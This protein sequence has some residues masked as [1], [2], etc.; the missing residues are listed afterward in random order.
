[1]KMGGADLDYAASVSQTSD[2]GY[3]AVGTTE[4]FGTYGSVWLI[5]LSSDPPSAPQ[6]LIA[7]AEGLRVTLR[8]R[9]SYEGD[10][11]EYRIYRDDRSPAI[12]WVDSVVGSPPDTFYY[13]SS[14]INDHV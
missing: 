11:V 10:I 2:G 4:S 9:Q 6:K 3:I 7:T 13:D 8:W 14:V 1:M 12:T 5:R